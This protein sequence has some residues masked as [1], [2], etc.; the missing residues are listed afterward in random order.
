MKK[1]LILVILFS[2]LPTTACCTTTNENNVG[3]AGTFIISRTENTKKYIEKWSNKVWKWRLL[4]AKGRN[5]TK[6]EQA[7]KDKL[8]QE[9]MKEYRKI[10]RIKLST[11]N[12]RITKF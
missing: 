12:N 10:N 9:I 8:E 5:L 2:I 7:D 11:K 1:L 3:L 4:E 6:K